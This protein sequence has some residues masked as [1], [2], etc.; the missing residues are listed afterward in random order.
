MLDANGNRYSIP[1][2][3]KEAGVPTSLNPSQ[4]KFDSGCNGHGIFLFKTD[5]PAKCFKLHGNIYTSTN[6]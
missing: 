3:S 1:L 4:N 5:S 6:D 2:E